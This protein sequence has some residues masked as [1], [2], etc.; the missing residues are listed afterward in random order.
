MISLGWPLVGRGVEK[1]ARFDCRAHIEEFYV[2]SQLPL[3]A[4][5]NINLLSKLLV[6]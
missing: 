2:H 3:S 1:K 5:A 4:Q 6:I